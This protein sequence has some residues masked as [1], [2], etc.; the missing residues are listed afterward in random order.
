ML[1][2]FTPNVRA[3]SAITHSDS[4]GL[5]TVIDAAASEAPK[6]RAFQLCVPACTAAE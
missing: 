4:G 5:S 6:K 2:E 1:Q 3:D